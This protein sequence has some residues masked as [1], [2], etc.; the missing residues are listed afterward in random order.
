[1]LLITPVLAAEDSTIED[2]LAIAEMA[3]QYSYRWDSKDSAGFAKLFT[4]DGVM[5][6]WVA[7][8]L[9]AGSRL[10]SREAILNYAKTSHE[11]RLADRQTRHHASGLVFIELSADTALTENMA[12]ITHQTAGTAPAFI[13]GSGI[14][15]NSW[16][17]TS[18]GWR[19]TKRMLFTDRFVEQ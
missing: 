1:M 13:S 5:E 6:R 16:R 9:V 19:I 10:D 7:G 15:R 8:E 17:K 18:E 11:G 14:Y 12:L 4:E 3:A 2:K